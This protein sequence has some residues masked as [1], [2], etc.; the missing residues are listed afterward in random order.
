[1]THHFLIQHGLDDKVTCPKLSQLLYDESKSIDKGIKTYEG[2]WH[3]LASGETKEN[4]DIA[5][6]DDIS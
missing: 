2:M 6:N 5:F 3:T 4:I 1:M